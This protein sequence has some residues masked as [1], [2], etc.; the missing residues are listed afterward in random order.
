MRVLRLLANGSRSQD[1]ANEL[2]MT[3]ITVK[4]KIQEISSKLNATNRV[5]AVAD[6]MRRGAI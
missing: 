1:I 6:A 4:H 3:E 5:Q 2:G